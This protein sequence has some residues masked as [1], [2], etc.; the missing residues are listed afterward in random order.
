MM[1]LQPDIYIE[2]V[3]QKN[4]EIFSLLSHITL[5]CTAKLN[6]LMSNKVLAVAN[7]W[8]ELKVYCVFLHMILTTDE[9]TVA[10]IV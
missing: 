6:Y 2:Q 8:Y 10:W 3:I 7:T 5:I 4:G 9:E 1:E